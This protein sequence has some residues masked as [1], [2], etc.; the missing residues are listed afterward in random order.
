MCCAPLVA[1]LPAAC[2]KLELLGSHKPC[3]AGPGLLAGP[4]MQKCSSQSQNV[5][6][7]SET[8]FLH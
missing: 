4:A 1:V 5:Y 6:F 8:S 7:S 3:K 2:V